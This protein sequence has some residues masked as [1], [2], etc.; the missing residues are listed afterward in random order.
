MKDLLRQNSTPGKFR[1]AD[2]ESKSGVKNLEILHL[3][4]EIKLQRLSWNFQDF[5]A[6]S[7]KWPGKEQHVSVSAE[8]LH[9]R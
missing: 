8:D 9:G 4:L 7:W 6:L 5:S 2:N 1:C 3:E